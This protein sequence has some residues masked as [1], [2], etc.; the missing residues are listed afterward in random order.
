[1][2]SNITI[3][4]PKQEP[5]SCRQATPLSL[6]GRRGGGTAFQKHSPLHVPKIASWRWNRVSAVPHG[7]DEETQL[8]FFR[9]AVYG[10]VSTI[11]RATHSKRYSPR[12]GGVMF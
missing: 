9:L 1:M 7:F 3:V 11:L 2:Y 10:C 5:S 6:L 8:F 12:R 4:I